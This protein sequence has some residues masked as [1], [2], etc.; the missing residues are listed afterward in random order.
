M[1]IC[2]AVGVVHW[3]ELNRLQKENDRETTLENEIGR[4]EKVS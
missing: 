3:K 2:I 4:E 1:Q